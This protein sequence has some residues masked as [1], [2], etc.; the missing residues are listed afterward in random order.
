MR[1]HCA[2][3]SPRWG[4]GQG[5]GKALLGLLLVLV[6]GCSLPYHAV[7]KNYELPD[8]T[9]GAG[10]WRT[11]DV[12]MR[13]GVKLKTHVL[14]PDGVERA[15]VVLMRNP[16]PYDVLFTL[17]CGVYARYGIGCVVQDVRGQRESGGEWYPL[18]HEMDDGEDTLAW[19]VQQ[20]FADTIALYGHSY[21]GGTALAA[22]GRLPPQVK[23]IVVGVFGTDLRA[24]MG[25]RG[26]FHHELITAW[27][28]FLEARAKGVDATDSYRRMLAHHPHAGA[29]EAVFG[30]KLSY[31][32][33]WIEATMPSARLW[34]FENTKAFMAVPEQIHVPVLFIQSMDDPFVVPGID[35]FNRLASK[36]QS[37]LALLPANHIGMQSGEVKVDGVDGQYTWKLPV[38]WLLHHLKGAPL[39]FEAH[40]VKS[41]PRNDSAPRVRD[42]WPGPTRDEQLVLRAAPVAEAPCPQHA[43]SAER[44]TSTESLAYRY[45]PLNPWRSEGGAR[46]IAFFITGGVTAGPVKQT[47]DCKRNDVVRFATAPL[48]R[49]QRLVGRMS[50]SLSV[51]STAKDTAF[52]AKLVDI[53]EQGLAVHVTDG[54]ATLRLPTAKDEA[55]VPYT[56]GEQR[57]VELDFLPTEWVLKPGHRLG[58]W[59]SSSSF[60][61]FSAHPNTETPW[62]LETQPLLATQTL[63]LGGAS[64]LTLHVGD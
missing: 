11:V 35:T 23:T 3:P 61:M 26:L 51:K 16:Y 6:A 27:I 20:P 44:A 10:S 60:P 13:D 38:P 48:E 57:T 54:A 5:E 8:F 24:S 42:E 25:E 62:Y 17:P 63:E 64:V 47:W 32:R 53:D 36:G 56:P 52:V 46:G 45:N 1:A 18:I 40:G 2:I 33:D 12:T 19:L 49:A 58:L 4:G 37:L 43:L 55:P 30:K 22:S 41:W 29:D 15:P 59:V 34:H 31:Y 28:A 50:L 9:N 7:R 39:P 14:M 21:L